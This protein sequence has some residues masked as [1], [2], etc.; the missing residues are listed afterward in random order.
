[1]LDSKEINVRIPFPRQKFF[2]IRY[3]VEYQRLRVASTVQE[4]WYHPSDDEL[5]E[6]RR[7]VSLS[8]FRP[9]IEYKGKEMRVCEKIVSMEFNN[10]FRKKAHK[11]QLYLYSPLEFSHPY[12]YGDYFQQVRIEINGLFHSDNILQDGHNVVEI[13]GNGQ[14]PV[15]KEGTNTITL[16]FKYHLL[17]EYAPRWKISA[18]LEKV[19]FE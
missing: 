19:E 9:A 6:R 17:F 8:G 3:Y 15:I 4:L 11:I 13:G 18:L 5:E 12:W 10:I 1:M 16:S 2:K 7:I 14:S